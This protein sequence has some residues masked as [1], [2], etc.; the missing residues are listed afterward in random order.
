MCILKN[1]W[2][3]AV[4]NVMSCTMD[5]LEASKQIDGARREGTAGWRSGKKAWKRGEG[6]ITPIVK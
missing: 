6:E 1:S 4:P 3:T 2:A 5:K